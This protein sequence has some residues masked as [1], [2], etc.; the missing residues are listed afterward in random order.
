MITLNNK[1]LRILQ[2]KSYKFPVKDLYHNFDTIAIPELH[3]YQLLILVH[4]FYTINTYCPLPLP[5][6]PCSKKVTPK[7]KS[8]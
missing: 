1:L 7:F 4:K 5:T 6:T 8:L 2:N 3:I